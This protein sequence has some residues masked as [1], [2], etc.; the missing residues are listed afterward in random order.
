MEGKKSDGTGTAT[1]ADGK[2]ADTPFDAPWEHIGPTKATGNYLILDR[3]GTCRATVKVSPRTATDP[4]N[5]AQAWQTCRL[6]V[7]APSMRVLLEYVRDELLR[8]DDGARF[9]NEIKLINEELERTGE[10]IT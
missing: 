5:E 9:G 1:P 2:Q 7:R 10:R 4:G 6:I 8:D 3:L